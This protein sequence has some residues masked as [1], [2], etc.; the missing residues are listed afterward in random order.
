[1]CQHAG[2]GESSGG[3]PE[4]REMGES[5]ARLHSCAGLGSGGRLHQGVAA[6]WHRSPETI[7]RYEV[8]ADERRAAAKL[9]AEAFLAE[10]EM[11]EAAE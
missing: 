10:Y 4:N 8:P 6:A 1:M 9:A 3:L 2:A 7:A 5:R 11:K